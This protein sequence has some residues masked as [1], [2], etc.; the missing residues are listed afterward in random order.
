MDNVEHAV[1]WC[2]RFDVYD[3]AWES[4]GFRS[5]KNIA[6]A[7]ENHDCDIPK[8]QKI[9][10]CV[11]FGAVTKNPCKPKLVDGI[12][13]IVPRAKHEKHSPCLLKS[14]FRIVKFHAWTLLSM[15][16]SLSSKIDF[17]HVAQKSV[18]FRS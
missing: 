11:G 4:V 2:S 17:S 12:P 7:Y 5:K 16:F 1:L 9:K 10:C 15:C 14:C 8:T 3:A 18:G 6:M 13:E